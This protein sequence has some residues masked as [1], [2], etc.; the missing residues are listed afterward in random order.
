MQTRKNSS[1]NGRVRFPK[2]QI[3]VEPG[4]GGPSFDFQ[5]LEIP[6]R[7]QKTTRRRR[8]NRLQEIGLRRRRSNKAG[9][10]VEE[11]MTVCI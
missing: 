11:I 3:P 4:P 6:I 5:A 9:G 1:S 7:Q 8:Y 2:Q 10:V